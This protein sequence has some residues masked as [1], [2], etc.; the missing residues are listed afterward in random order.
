MAREVGP[1]D[2]VALV[3]RAEL[4][5]RW[6]SWLALAFLVAIVGGVV[7][8]A[9]A[10]GNRTATAFPRFVRAHGYDAFVS[11]SAETPL[12]ALA[13]L[14]GV[15][16]AIQMPYAIN[17]QPRCAC[18]HTVNA[19]NTYVLALTPRELTRTVNLVAGRMPVQSDPD[20]VLA[21]FTLEQDNGVHVGTVLHIPLYARSQA[22]AVYASSGP[23]PTPTGPTVSL[24][25]V[26]IAAAEY[27]FPVGTTPDY[28]LYTTRAFAR[29]V[30][31]RTA[32]GF[33]YLVSLREGTAG[34]AQF[35]SDTKSLP[36]IAYLLDEDSPAVLV[37]GAIHPQAV[38][39]WVLA[40]LAAL[41][42]MAV[43]GQALSRQRTVEAEEY[44][45]LRSLGMTPHQLG[46]LG[47]LGT[48]VVAVA[49][50]V[51]AIV[52]A[53]ALSD[54]APVGEARFAQP[55]GGFVFD[56]PVLLLGALAIVVVV[57]LLGLW[58][59]LRA[60]YRHVG[61]DTPQLQRPSSLAAFLGRA[62]APPPAVIGVRSALERGRSTTSTPVTTAALGTVLAVMALCATAVFGSSLSHLTTTPSL[63][64]DG[65]QLIVGAPGG[66]HQQQYLEQVVT[67][68]EHHAV[69]QDISLTTGGPVLINNESAQIG[70][71]TAIRGPILFSSVSGD[72]PRGTGQI[73][74]GATTM[75]QV[76]AHIGSAVHVS[77]PEP[78]GG[79]RTVS[80][81]VVGIVALPTG[82]TSVPVGL[83]SGAVMSLDGYT[84]DTCPPSPSRAQ[85]LHL[86]AQHVNYALF[87]RAIPGPQGRAA[88][89]H[90][91]ST[92][93]VVLSPS[94]PTGLVNFGEAVDF[95]LIFGVMLAIFGAAT[96]I[97]LLVVSVGRRRHETGL[98]KAIGFVNRQVA[99][100]VFWQ[101][102]TVAVLGI[103]VGIP[104]GIVIGRAVWDAFALNIGVVPFPV[105]D[106]GLLA[107]IA[108]CVLA[109]T[110]L[111]ALGPSI[112]AA[113]AQPGQLLRSE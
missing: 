39:W 109:A 42:G 107:I 5:R 15:A 23:G 106:A 53:F 91:A 85:C 12:P 22:A 28:D 52:L 57:G 95:P 103:V 89:A 88:I 67:A 79:R 60:A 84:G 101:A 86:L 112:A 37:A 21:S 94:T 111:L 71:S 7:L 98:L 10:G 104:L 68:L 56:V 90:M 75:R 35:K 29:S 78:T 65:F 82:L 4:R 102:T 18:T 6:R 14:P 92:Y 1:V 17:G 31:P 64:G 24:H 49:G 9:V 77:F 87:V 105:V 13:R 66:V 11:D 38:G 34:Y 48:F 47:L 2:V 40:L 43:I 19:V 54:V 93:P 113:R 20:E 83:G 36:N 3:V 97:H 72:L 33:D 100:T 108:A 76:G 51:G 16:S 41:A 32:Q 61:G 81:R 25:V 45:T 44:P 62:G 99:A 74:L 55:S 96:L 27:E 50:A 30:L 70:A 110:A 69:I 26:G 63:Y 46:L 73:A 59:A 58:P 8:A 80:L